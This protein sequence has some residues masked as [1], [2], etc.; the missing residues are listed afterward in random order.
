MVA[1]WTARNKPGPKTTYRHKYREVPQAPAGL[2][3][4][5]VAYQLIAS[6]EAESDRNL[7]RQRE[8]PRKVK[9]KLT[10][11]E[12]RQDENNRL[13]LLRRRRLQKQ[14]H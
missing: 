12:Q 13:Q 7:Q 2:G 3:P 8:Q 1:R 5:L 4:D 10:A 6:G 11:E 9:E 14:Q